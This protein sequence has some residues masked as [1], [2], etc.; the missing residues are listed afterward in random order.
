MKKS[1]YFVLGCL[2]TLSIGLMIWAFDVAD[3]WRG[4]NGTGGEVFTIALPLILVWK[5]ISTAEQTETEKNKE[6]QRLR[7]ILKQ[8]SSL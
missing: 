1:T 6:I 7:N 2:F 3:M 5:I 8:K 4:Y